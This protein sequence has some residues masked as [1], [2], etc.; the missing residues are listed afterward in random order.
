[1]TRRDFFRFIVLG[2]LSGYLIK[3]LGIKTKTKKAMFWRK[4]S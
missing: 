2:G 3:K 1:M 4:V